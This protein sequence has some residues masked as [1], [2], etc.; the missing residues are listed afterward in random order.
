MCY[1]TNFVLA[2]ITNTKVIKTVT[3][4]LKN[5]FFEF[6]IILS[7]LIFFVI[8]IIYDLKNI[9]FEPLGPI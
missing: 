6:K 7:I 3:S 9:F 2:S 8:V 4:F 1:K 5:D